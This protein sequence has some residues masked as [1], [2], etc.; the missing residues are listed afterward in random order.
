MQKI[1]ELCDS[2]TNDEED[3]SRKVKTKMK[4]NFDDDEDELKVKK[5]VNN[6]NYL[7]N[8]IKKV[9][10]ND[11]K[12]EPEQKSTNTN[13]TNKKKIVNKN[14]L[15]KEDIFSDNLLENRIKNRINNKKITPRKPES[16]SSSSNNLN[17]SSSSDEDEEFY[18]KRKNLP[19]NKT[20]TGYYSFLASL[21]GKFINFR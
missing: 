7:E 2:D 10:S 12:K 20:I 18:N 15:K 5:P 17:E 21:S 4:L 3:I 16:S 9:T 11:P 13:V 8:R 14:R 1:R 19:L 6:I